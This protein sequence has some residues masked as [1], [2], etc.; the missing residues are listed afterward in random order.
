MQSLSPS[1]EL[2]VWKRHQV[3]KWQ[4]HQQTLRKPEKLTHI[5][6]K[7]EDS[8]S[9]E[10]ENRRVKLKPDEIRTLLAKEEGQRRIKTENTLRLKQIHAQQLQEQRITTLQ[11]KAR[12]NHSRY[13]E[14]KETKSILEE[15]EQR[16]LT[17][18]LQELEC[19]MEKS[20]EIH[21]AVMQSRSQSVAKRRFRSGSLR[22]RISSERLM[23][24]L[25]KVQEKRQKETQAR[26]EETERRESAK[27][28]R[29]E[30]WKKVEINQEMEKKKVTDWTKSIED[31][32]TSL[33]SVIETRLVEN[34]KAY[35][36]RTDHLRELQD[37][38]LVNRE[39]MRRMQTE[40]QTDLLW[41]WVDKGKKLE[42]MKME[43]ALTVQRK[44]EIQRYDMLER[45]KTYSLLERVARS[46]NPS[47][48]HRLLKQLEASPPPDSLV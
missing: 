9:D 8:K 19:R 5:T 29:M 2:L 38:C 37:L 3:M 45:E 14:A 26:N 21:T 6:T 39:R 10:G 31:K 24:Y 12:S 30:R 34:H 11:Q 7:K 25:R 41:K 40:R 13:I 20:R 33:A 44:R 32:H 17:S 4:Q 18:R 23:E 22:H 27:K 15:E 42:K 16:E 1:R 46:P 47:K 43:R 36:S 48:A 28:A 35:A